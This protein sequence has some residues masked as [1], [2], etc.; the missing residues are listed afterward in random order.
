M[1]NFQ[2]M[3]QMGQKMQARMKEMREK[4]ADLEV[5]ARSGGG[6][7]EVTANGEGE[8]TD[9]QLDP[10]VV[11][12]EDVEMLED[13]ILSAVSE[14][15][16]RADEKREEAMKEATGGLPMDGLDDLGGLSGLLG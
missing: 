9:I 1:K 16:R 8:I 12:P 4:L 6:M 14:A 13:L 7:V 2:Q 11:D 10:E 15:Q 5:T 3:M